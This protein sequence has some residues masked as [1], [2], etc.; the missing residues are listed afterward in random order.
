LLHAALKGAAS[1]A[2]I[3]L[4]S[5]QDTG[6]AAGAE[7]EVRRLTRAMDAALTEARQALGTP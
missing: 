4:E 2:A 1:N 3:N 7:A 6:F 5:L